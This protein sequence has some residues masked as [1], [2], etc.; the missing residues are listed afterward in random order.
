MTISGASNDR[1]GELIRTALSSRALLV[2]V[3]AAA[4]AIVLS[5]GA[6]FAL[7]SLPSEPLKVVVGAK[8]Y[9][10]EPA[11]A[12]VRFVRAVISGAGTQETYHSGDLSGVWSGIML[13]PSLVFVAAVALAG[14]L[15]RRLTRPSLVPRAA[16]LVVAALVSAVSLGIFAALMS[17]KITD[18][19]TT[20]YTHDGTTYFLTTLV[21][22]FLAG[23][24][25]FGVVR[26]LPKPWPRAL[27]QAGVF[28]LLL[29]VVGGLA[30]SAFILA[31]EVKGGEPT[32]NGVATTSQ[33]AAAHAGAILPAVAGARFSL[34]DS[35]VSSAFWSGGENEYHWVGFVHY[36]DA[37]RQARVLGYAGE[38]GIGG[39][40]IALA[41]S[42]VLV[43][44]I[45]G[46]TLLLVWRAKP[47]HALAG[48]WAGL[49][50]GLAF[51]IVTVPVMVLSRISGSST[52][53]DGG[54][55]ARTRAVC[56][57][58]NGS[59]AYTAVMLV[60]VCALAGLV[61]A[62]LKQPRQAVGVAAVAPTMPV[63]LASPV[64]PPLA[65]ATG[66]CATCGTPFGDAAVRFCSKCGAARN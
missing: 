8:F 11:S 5:A 57:A 35:N 14:L 4:A 41:F 6:L 53:S 66:F 56:G 15:A 20:T 58:S 1:A 52:P 10:N 32:R 33:Y 62:A 64:G 59:I 38:F 44:V 37:H 18:F 39:K 51:A 26:L 55:Y 2:G 65:P 34:G 47:P 25:S 43:V 30:S 13:V 31:N 29:M 60:A 49:V 50:Q 61:Y 21:L 23:A 24:F 3:A 9:V 42:L 17:Y 12:G 63:P 45:V 27:S 22:F 54:S 40:L 16:T 48:L 36:I 19:G 46:L 28:M 7:G